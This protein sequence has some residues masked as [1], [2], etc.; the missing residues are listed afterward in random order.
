MTVTAHTDCVVYAVS[1]EALTNFF[2]FYPGLMIQFLNTL[3]FE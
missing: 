2:E 3:Y 1:K